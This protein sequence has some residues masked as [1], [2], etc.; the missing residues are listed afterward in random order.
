MIREN[1]NQIYNKMADCI[2]KHNML[3]KGESVIACVS[4]GCDSVA[5]LLLLTRFAA[6]KGNHVLC[7]HFDHM[8]RGEESDGDREFVRKL[9]TE[10]KIEF[11]YERQDAAAYAQKKR[12]SLEEGAREIRYEYFTRLAKEKNA[13]IA[14]AHNRNDRVET[15]LLNIS[16][17]TGI[18]GLKGISYTRDNIIRPLLDISRQEL[19]IVCRESGV[20]YRT[21]SSNLQAFCGRNKIRLNVL[22]YLRE[23]LAEDI[24]EKLYRLSVLAERDNAFLDKL[25]AREYSTLVSVKDGALFIENPERFSELEEAL[26][27]RVAIEILKNYFPGGRGIELKMV[28]A[29]RSF[30]EKHKVGSSMEISCEIGARV[31]HDGILITDLC[32]CPENSAIIENVVHMEP[33]YCSPEEAFEICKKNRGHAEAFDRDILEKICGDG[34]FHTKVRYRQEGDYFTPYGASG[35]KSLKKFLID[36]KIPAYLRNRIPL[37]VCG[38]K[39]IWVCGVMRSNIAPITKSTENAV[40]FKYSLE[41]ERM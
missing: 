39:I 22:P 2:E 34:R 28:E 5:L 16:R 21:D 25:A 10:L 8:L 36:R 15:V 37:L 17:G 27:S 29:L 23:N 19:E 26:K 14:V 30:M 20:A 35:G 3:E 24:D 33:I 12:L 11:C 40:V 32:Y 4:G 31:Y 1:M 6:E 13:K 7:A 9:C 38:D 18:H 41:N